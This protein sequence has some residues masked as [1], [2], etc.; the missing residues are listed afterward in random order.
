MKIVFLEQCDQMLE[1][2]VDKCIPKVDQKEVNHCCFYLNSGNFQKT[3]HKRSAGI[4]AKLKEK[5]SIRRGPI[6]SHCLQITFLVVAAA[7]V[8]AAVVAA[9]GIVAATVVIAV[10][11]AAIVVVVIAAIVAA[12]VAV[13]AAVAASTLASVGHGASRTNAS[14][15]V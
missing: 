2:N 14:M 6:W 15:C 10:I 7:V 12:A 9:V 11:V 13:V 1:Q 8:A 3:Q 5:L 4:W